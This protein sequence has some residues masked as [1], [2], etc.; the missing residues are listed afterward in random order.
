MGFETDQD[1]LLVI[2]GN[3]RIGNEKRRNQGMCVM[4]FSAQ[5]PLDREFHQ[6]RHPFHFT[7]IMAITNQTS[8]FSARALDPVKWKTGD[9]LIIKILRNLIAIFDENRYH[10][11]DEGLCSFW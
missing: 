7:G 1:L 4:A 3:L 2:K 11:L 6:Y 10:N 8:L 9:N 5:D